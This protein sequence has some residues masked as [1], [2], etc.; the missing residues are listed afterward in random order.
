MK[1]Q[2]L[3]QP[4]HF[5]LALACATAA[6]TAPLAGAQTVQVAMN[7]P[8]TVTAD[9]VPGATSVQLLI[10]V[11]AVTRL[12]LDAI[13]PVNGA[14]VA[15]IDPS[16]LT[17]FAPGDSRVAYQ[18]G[19]VRTPP[20]PGGIFELPDI[21]SPANGTWRLVVSFPPAIERTVVLVTVIAASRYTVGVVIDRDVLLVGE[22]AAMGVAVQ[23]NGVPVQGLAPV[24]AISRVGSSSGSNSA[25]GRDDGAGP[26][27]RAN[28]GIYSIERTFTQA[29]EYDIRADVNIATPGGLVQR[30]ALRRVRVDLPALDPPAVTL[31]NVL[32]TGGCVSGL[33]VNLGLNALRAGSFSL[34]V[35]LLGSNGRSID[36]R[37]ALNLNLGAA[38]TSALFAAQDIKQ[39]IAVDGPYVVSLIDI[40]NIGGDEFSLAFRRRDAGSFN[41]AQAN[42]CM[43]PIELPG[44]LTVTPVLKG[45]FIGSLNFSFPIRVSVSG[46]YQISF[47]VIAAGGAD[48]GLINASRNL[49]A[50]LNNVTVNLASEA[51]LVND[52]PYQVVSLLV[53]N[54]ANSARLSVVG[55]S[56]AYSRWQF[57]PRINGDLNN[58]GSVDAADNTLISRFRGAAVLNPGDRRDLNRDGVIDLRDARELQ[59]LA[60]TAPNCPIV[61]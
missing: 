29:G 42:L 56:E 51:Y 21:N 6:L 18:P 27:G 9:V 4:G 31:A 54:N 24:L 41:V 58:D 40:L 48:L 61:Q 16:G 47:K 15:L 7:T 25:T 44:P 30:T 53:L 28:D 43:L 13:V 59:R 39:T 46:S 10:P 33:Q 2:F 38:S 35:R 32:G 5:L 17:V 60:C 50:G 34:L 1:L 55:S 26:D 12:R 49:S 57:A 45:S 14:S 23:D 22:D 3:K 37:R 20:L 36:V 11:N 19:F 52:G 8:P